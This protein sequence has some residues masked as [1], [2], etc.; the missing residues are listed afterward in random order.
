MVRGINDHAPSAAEWV[1][2]VYELIRSNEGTASGEAA[3]A[4]EDGQGAGTGGVAGSA[5]A[6]SSG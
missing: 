5:A 3:A 2:P 4:A 6:S 1:F